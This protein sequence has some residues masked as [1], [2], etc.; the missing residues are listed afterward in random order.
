[1]CSLIT[2]INGQ[3]DD[4]FLNDPDENEGAADE[5]TIFNDADDLSTYYDD[6]VPRELMQ[7]SRV[8]EYEPLRESD[9]MWQRR[10]WRVVDTREKMNMGFRNADRP[11]FTILKDLAES[12][13]I[14]V[15]RDE[16][17]KEPLDNDDLSAMMNRIDTAVVYDPE[18]YEEKI[19]ITEN[20]LDPE[21]VK[22]Y[23]VKEVWFFDKKT[24][25]V[26]VRILGIAPILDKFDENTGEFLYE[27]PMFWAYYPKARRFLAKER[28]VSDFNDVAPMSWYDLFELRFFAS[29]IY[30]QSNSLGQRLKDQFPDSEYDRLLASEKIKQ[31]LFNWEHDLWTY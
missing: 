30:A 18:T 2:A 20:P 6:I 16:K 9:V 13:D 22:R 15:F 23:R 27:I 10:I 8:I 29:Y 1:M 19:V 24:S 26:K 12:G 4:F 25:Q 28:V 7:E 31:E 5:A 14:K 11:F 3:D 17:F 21:D